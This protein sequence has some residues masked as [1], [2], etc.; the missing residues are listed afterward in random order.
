MSPALR[1]PDERFASLPGFAFAPHYLEDLPGFRGLRVHH[2]D[3]GPPGARQV[4]LCL[5]GE[6]TW[7]Y[8]YRRMIP[9]LARAGH[10][11]V[12]PDL[13][14][15]GRSD[16]PAEDATYTFDFHRNLLLALVER[17]DLK[18]ITLVVQ[19][20]GGLLGL[21]LPM[22][23]PERFDRLLVMNTTLATGDVPLG[24][25]FLAWR[26]F[27]NAHPD[28]ACGKLLSR[29]C[30]H[31]TEGEAAAYDAPFPDARFKAGVRSFPNL[32]PDAPDAPGAEISRKARQW[33]GSTWRG[34]SF[35][36]VGVRD[37]VLGPPVMAQL[38]A[39]IRGCPEPYLHPQAGH[40]VPE[41]GEEIARAALARF[42]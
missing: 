42:R 5:H 14:G 8:L 9:V 27:A 16:K 19:D 11:V 30:P 13:L 24:D 37:P 34:E 26:A 29:T 17:L 2:V 32:V 6:P 40:F 4:F 7:S 22:E 10:R 25:G 33:L 31:L 41:W 1:T 21:T 35:M 23:L 18:G 15:F 12:A 39:A 38:R 20:W 28:L 36:V 3:E